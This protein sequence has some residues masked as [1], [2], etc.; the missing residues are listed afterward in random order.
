MPSHKPIQKITIADGVSYSIDSTTYVDSF[1]VSGSPTLTTNW[2]VTMTG[3]P[4]EGMRLSFDY[5]ASP[6][7]AGNHVTFLGTQ[8]PDKYV[9]KKVNID[10]YY[11]GTAWV[12]EYTPGF[13]QTGIISTT[14]IEDDAITTSKILAANVTLA[15]MEPLTSG[16][17]VVGNGSNRPT[18]VT[19]TGDISITNAGVTAIGNDKITNAMINSS[20]AIATS[21]LA[22][23]SDIAKLANVTQAELELLHDVTVGT[24]A[25]SKVVTTDASNKVAALDITVLSINGVAVAATGA[26]LSE[27][28]SAGVVNNDFKLIAGA[29]AAG[30][31]ASDIQ[32]TKN[33]V[34]KKATKVCQTESTDAAIA[35]D[36]EVVVVILSTVDLV[37]TLPSVATV[38]NQCIDFIIQDNPGAV[39]DVTF[40]ADGSDA[41][42][43][44]ATEATSK[45]VSTP[46]INSTIRL[47]NNVAGVW[48][49]GV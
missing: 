33:L 23:A 36:T 31:S 25:A 7:L 40:V 39:Y 46:A 2:A 4:Y 43:Y 16:Q 28:N 12:V 35:A 49:I 37:F 47:M 15:K 30:V 6:T 19:P 32:A 21:K 1:Y 13:E 8:M 24:T 27:L 45:K 3:T 10:C 18:A 48:T 38:T 44:G 17:I 11:N 34:A 5:N 41:I 29:A 26:E 20:A 9:A 42:S 22:A 14:Q